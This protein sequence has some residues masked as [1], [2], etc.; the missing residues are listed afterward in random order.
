MRQLPVSSYFGGIVKRKRSARGKAADKPG[1]PAAQ[2][3]GHTAWDRVTPY[4]QHTADRVGP[5]AHAA[6]SRVAPAP[7]PWRLTG[8]QR[9][10]FSW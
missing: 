7:L 4:V 8:F 6:A 5:V 3:L 9:F 10:T 2:E 1:S